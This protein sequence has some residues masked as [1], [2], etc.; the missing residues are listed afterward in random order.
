ME[1]HDIYYALVFLC[2]MDIKEPMAISLSAGFV[3][4]SLT[5]ISLPLFAVLHADFPWAVCLPTSIAEVNLFQWWLWIHNCRTKCY[6]EVMNEKCYFCC[7]YYVINTVFGI[8]ANI[9]QVLR[10]SVWDSVFLFCCVKSQAWTT[11]LGNR[12]KPFLFLGAW[13]TFHCATVLILL[14]FRRLLLNY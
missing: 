10:F 2:C 14:L 1:C 9:T 4:E 13:S 8:P 5:K 12:F 6:T 7:Y 3:P 11:L